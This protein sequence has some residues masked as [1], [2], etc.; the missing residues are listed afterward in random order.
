M[1]WLFGWTPSRLGSLRPLPPTGSLRD[2][3]LHRTPRANCQ[4]PR[5]IAPDEAQMDMTVE[6][7]LPM[8]A[9][10]AKALNSPARREAA[11]RYLSAL[12]T[13]ERVRDV[14]AAAIA[15]AKREGRVRGLTDEDIDAELEAWRAENKV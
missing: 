13:G 14:L 12:L 15:D 8:D 3:G 9:E 1:T 5:Y 2:P 10:A 6:V 7:T 4:L 11:G